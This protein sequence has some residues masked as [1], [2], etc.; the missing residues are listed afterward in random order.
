MS[1]TRHKHHLTPQPV[2]PATITPGEPRATWAVELSPQTEEWQ[3]MDGDKVAA[4]ATMTVVSPQTATVAR[5]TVHLVIEQQPG[6]TITAV[7]VTVD[8]R[9]ETP[10]PP[11][12]A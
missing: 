2:T 9:K 3:L 5:R 12:A 11:P 7:E 8:A 1:A 6:Y 4:A 10:C